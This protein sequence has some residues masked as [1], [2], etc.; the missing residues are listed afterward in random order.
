[1]RI[2][3]F[4]SQFGHKLSGHEADICYQSSDINCAMSR[5]KYKNRYNCVDFEVYGR[6]F[7]FRT[8]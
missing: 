7:F 2:E 8:V 4:N 5:P 3:H 6:R 1:M